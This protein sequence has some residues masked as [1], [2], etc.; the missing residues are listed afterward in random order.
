MTISPALVSQAQGDIST[1]IIDAVYSD[2]SQKLGKSVAR[3]GDSQFSWEEDV[4][5]DTSLG[6]PQP[7]QNYTQVTTRAYKI[8]IVYQGV[9]YS[10]RSTKDGGVIFQCTP[11]F[12]GPGAT[13]LAPETAI[14]PSAPIALNNPLAFID[15]SGNVAVSTPGQ[16]LA[17]LLTND[18]NAQYT[19]NAPFFNANRYYGRFR[20]S[21]DG[22]KF[23][24]TDLR[25]GTAYVAVSGQAPIQVA[26]GVA[27]MLPII[28]SSDGTKIVFAVS[29][30]EHKGDN[31]VVQQIQAVQLLGNSVS[32]PIYASSFVV[33]VGCGGGNPDPADNAFNVEAGFGGSNLIMEWTDQGLIHSTACSGIGIALTNFNGQDLWTAPQIARAAL[34]PDR[35]RLVGVASESAD[36]LAL[37]DVA[38]GALTPL[39][40][41]VSVDQVAWSA[42]GQTVVYSTVTPGQSVNGTPNLAVGMQLFNGQWPVEG[43][44]FNVTLWRVPVTGG[45]S[46]KLFQSQGRAI[47]VIAP[48][49]DNSS[50]AF[51]FIQSTAAMVQLINGGATAD[52]ALAAVPH[53][54]LLS[55]KWDGSLTPS[56]IAQGGQPAYSKG[57]F[58]PI[59]GLVAPV[60]AAPTT[61]TIAPTANLAPPALAIGGN[62]MVNTS[63]GDTLNLRQ[64]PGRTAPILGIL[65]PG[66]I[67]T[68]E[69]GPQS[70]DGLRWWKIR[71]A[72]NVVGWVVDQVTDAE[73]TVNTLIPQ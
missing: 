5:N 16:P 9:T 43:R 47:G 49:P 39:Q 60:A 62:A 65:K 30:N 12:S 19:Q 55:V 33:S 57:S 15:Y 3:G 71:T 66:V 4:F 22:T 26:V 11:N 50:V 7:G 28:W 63:K 41:E 27:T 17:H 72:D 31:G 68:I 70:A 8:T 18:A 29:T 54:Q 34:S 23:I 59:G 45:P 36:P 35:K 51:S 52:Q 10:Y 14:P 48:A 20:W 21:P 24:Y 69:E 42:D 64:A 61:P 46:T 58:T 37:V 56:T 25:S 32:A 38:T 6:C 53:A 73:G 67:V 1:T 40:S 44:V 2:L 13:P